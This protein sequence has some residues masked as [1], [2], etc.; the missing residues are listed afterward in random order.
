[1]HTAKVYGKSIGGTPLS[2]RSKE[3]QVENGRESRKGEVEFQAM[4]T[5][6]PS[7]YN[8][9]TP[10]RTQAHVVVATQQ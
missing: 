1:M 4:I 7:Y 6:K 3:N 2:K 9:K 8:S 10:G 5:S